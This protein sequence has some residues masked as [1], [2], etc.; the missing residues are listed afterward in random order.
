MTLEEVAK[1]LAKLESE[2]VQL[3]TAQEHR[4]TEN[5][6]EWFQRFGG[7]MANDPGFVDMINSGKAWREAQHDDFENQPEIG[8]A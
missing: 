6:R 4:R 2:I 3:K 1:R 7:S 5:A 8:A